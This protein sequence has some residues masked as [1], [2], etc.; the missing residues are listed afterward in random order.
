MKSGGLKSLSLDGLAGFC[1]LT[2]LV[3]VAV[4]LHTITFTAFLL[5]GTIL[6]LLTGLLRSISSDANP[7]LQGIVLCAGASIPA[8]VIGK[9]AFAVTA[10]RMLW[11]FIVPVAIACGTGAQVQKLW[12]RQHRVASV[13]TLLS[14]IILA[15]LIGKFVVPRMMAL[16]EYDAEDKPAPEFT[17]ASLDGTPVSLQSLKGHV[18]VLDFWATWCAPCVAEMP[19]LNQ[20]YKQYSGHGD[21]VFLAVNSGWNDDSPDKIRSFLRARR[22]DI[23]V[24]LDTTNVAK[25]LGVETLPS[26]VLIDRNGH[27]RMKNSG[28]N[29]NDDLQRKLTVQV[30]LLLHTN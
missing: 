24:A 6:F 3:I 27:I 30:D 25:S 1:A 29:E 28:Y 5:F 16:S 26:L 23:P 15:S 10:T 22:L 19:M 13:G 14:L 2:L 7:W 17:L 4:A 8:V 12:R 20:T 21:V 18:I 9:A 11:G